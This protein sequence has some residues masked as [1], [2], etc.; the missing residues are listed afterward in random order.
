MAGG[1]SFWIFD[2]CRR[3]WDF[4]RQFHS[5]LSPLKADFGVSSAAISLLYGAARLEGGFEGPLIGYLISRFGP[6]AMIVA[7]ASMAG[8]GLILLSWVDS[9][10][11]FFFIY[12]FIAS[13][14]ANAGFYHPVSTAV[15][16][17]FIRRR[18]V[19]F[20]CI[21]ASINIGGMILAPIL[22]YII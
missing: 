13:V 20:S 3:P 15:N 5:I 10:W 12:T 21:S 9:F 14:G 11:S 22:S 7:G 1:S 6:R 8:I 4:S 18:G 2:K 17:W 19:G 16:N